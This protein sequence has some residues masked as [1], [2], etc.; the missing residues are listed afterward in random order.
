MLKAP[1]RKVVIGPEDH[2]RRMSLDEFDQAVGA[3]GYLYE[4]N[5]SEKKTAMIR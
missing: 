5:S 1:A 3:E 4:L 2:G